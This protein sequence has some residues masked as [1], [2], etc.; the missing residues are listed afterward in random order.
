MDVNSDCYSVI[1][2]YHNSLSSWN[3]KW[4]FAF[5]EPRDLFISC[6]M[7]NKIRALIF[8]GK[9]SEYSSIHST[10]YTKHLPFGTSLVLSKSICL[11]CWRLGFDPWVGK[12]P[13]RSKW[14]PTPVFLPGKSHGRRSLAGYSPWDRKESDTTEQFHFT[15]LLPFTQEVK[16]VSKKKSIKWNMG[17]NLALGELTFY[18]GGNRYLKRKE[19]MY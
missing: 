1:I 16:L 17:K 3:I 2:T 9:D 13:C 10:I 19:N 6:K 11:Q 4:R 12:I 14:H 8:L 15:S 5:L 18:W 7:L